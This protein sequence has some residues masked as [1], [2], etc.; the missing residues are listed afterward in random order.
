MP[1]PFLIV[2]F[3][4]DYMNVAQSSLMPSLVTTKL[5]A[6]YPLHP[7]VHSLI[8]LALNFT[9]IVDLVITVT[10][11]S[12]YFNCLSV[13]RCLFLYLLFCLPVCLCL[14]VRLRTCLTL[15][16]V[17]DDANLFSFTSV[18]LSINLCVCKVLF[19]LLGTFHFCREKNMYVRGT[20][21]KK[22]IDKAG[23]KLEWVWPTCVF[24]NLD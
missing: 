3:L 2:F 20:E 1:C 13:R 4:Q 22:L 11:T 5:Q 19:F 17:N 21:I 6:T 16:Y 12:I 9:I 23:N 18:F 7:R 8:K 14:F 15:F 24:M 10:A